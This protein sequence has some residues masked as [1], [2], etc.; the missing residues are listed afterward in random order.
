MNTY[1]GGTT[2]SAGRLLLSGD[3]ST[4]GVLSIDNG[5]TLELGG[6]ETLSE[7]S[8]L[9]S[10]D[11]GSHSLTLDHTNNYRFE[12][13]IS[14][15][16]VL[17]K[18]GTG[19]LTLGGVNTYSGGT[20]I[21]AGTLSIG[22]ADNIGTGVLTLNSG[23]LQTTG[24]TDIDLGSRGVM[25]GS[26]GGTF[27][28]A[29][30]QTLSLGGAIGGTGGLTKSGT[31]TLTLGG[32][33]TYSGGTTISGN[34]SF[35][36]S[37]AT[38]SLSIGSVTLAANSMVSINSANISGVS[39]GT[40]DSSSSNQY[41]LTINGGGIGLDFMN[42]IGGTQ[43][44]GDLCIFNASEIRFQNNVNVAG[45]IK[46]ERISSTM[47]TG[48][49]QDTMYS[50]IT[51]NLIFGTSTIPLGV[52]VLLN[53]TNNDID[54]LQLNTT[55]QFQ[56][57][58]TDGFR[59]EGNISTVTRNAMGEITGRS[60]LSLVT[61]SVTLGG[62]VTSG[63][64]SIGTNGNSDTLT[65]A[66]GVATTI[67][68]PIISSSSFGAISL[69]ENIRGG[70]NTF[71][72]LP[73]LLGD[74]LVIGALNQTQVG[75][76]PNTNFRGFQGGLVIGVRLNPENSNF[77]SLGLDGSGGVENE[78][79]IYHA[80]TIHIN[81]DIISG[82]P[83]I[84][85][86]QDDIIMG[87]GV[88]DISS[89]GVLALV[90]VGV[91]DGGTSSITAN[92]VDGLISAE[93]VNNQGVTLTGNRVFLINTGELENSR[94]IILALNGGEVDIATQ[95]NRIDFHQ[96]SRFSDNQTLAETVNML[97]NQQIDT[98]QFLMRLF[99]NAVSRV[100]VSDIEKSRILERVIAGLTVDSGLAV[101]INPGSTLVN[102]R[103]IIFVDLGVFEEELSLYSQIGVGI[104][105]ALS[106]CEEE[107]GCTPAVTDVELL[108]LLNELEARIFELERRLPEAEG[109]DVDRI[110]GLLAGFRNEFKAYSGYL[111]ELR[112]IQIAAAEDLEED[113]FEEIE[114]EVIAIQLQ[115][116]RTNELTVILNVVRNRI[117]WFETLK[118]DA[119]ERE[120]ISRATGLD[121]SIELLDK[122][123]EAARSEASFIEGQ[124]RLLL[125][126]Q[127]AGT[128]NLDG[129]DVS[130]LIGDY[131]LDEILARK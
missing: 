93:N 109:T 66:D 122:L 29:T 71:L 19:T 61:P 45:N 102:Q 68:A 49:T 38:A 43:R 118:I 130:N 121:I 6:S 54:V 35:M 52:R 83:V 5:A 39:F 91:P 26:G 116:A 18:S 55:G 114:E 115:G 126:S 106:Q 96:E 105:L 95:G 111:Q 22:I 67:D 104:A 13:D 2:I 46:F 36:N 103:I 110:K 88:S 129:D 57:A 77:V 76:N 15:T 69:P 99:A 72:S 98:S 60:E 90:A 4:S 32:V 92:N 24:M 20:T 94:L 30:S 40:I 17:T 25:L 50:I 80:S 73:G 62:D 23:I 81:T 123:I 128:P 87:E 131:V 41:S 10:V 56:L 8:G 47:G 75:I 78:P 107:E 97:T 112:D 27:N 14:G 119:T 7:L 3:L 79:V 86:A 113:I 59:T 65:I 9:G 84:I 58:D 51:E 108:G 127:S 37:Q 34:I 124:L 16:G 44:L 63:T 85:I 74:D 21:S 100:P 82:G 101:A 89:A 125:E 48:I 42:A 120:E 70:V 12:G 64:L 28:V 1:S 31:G 53:S 33:N 117:S 11:L